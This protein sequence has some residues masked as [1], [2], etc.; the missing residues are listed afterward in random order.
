LLSI[1]SLLKFSQID[2]SHQVNRVSA[3]NPLSIIAGKVVIEECNLAPLSM[4]YCLMLSLMPTTRA[5][6]MQLLIGSSSGKILGKPITYCFSSD[7][8]MFLEVS[9]KSLDFS[10]SPPEINF[11]VL[12]GTSFAGIATMMPIAEHLYICRDNGAVERF[13]CVTRSSPKEEDTF[14][15]FDGAEKV[16]HLFFSSSVMALSASGRLVSVAKDSK[17]EAKQLSIF[18][19]KQCRTLKE[20][21]CADS[22]EG[23]LAVAGSGPLGSLTV[24]EVDKSVDKPIYKAKPILNTRLNIPVPEDNR[25]IAFLGPDRVVVGTALG[26]LNVFDISSAEKAIITRQVFEKGTAIRALYKTGNN[27]QVI[28]VDAQN[29]IELYDVARGRGLGRFPGHEGSIL[30]VA[31]ARWKQRNLLIT[32]SHDRYMRIFD[33]NT[34]KLLFK[35]YLKQVPRALHVLI[36]Q[37]SKQ[38]LTDSDEERLWDE[39]PVAISDKRRKIDN[40]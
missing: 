32:G 36:K 37:D 34:R 23:K 26:A 40:N 38:D 35:Q 6:K 17:D 33:F 16:A 9:C 11:S 24:F 5:L 4:Q 14:L 21:V 1:V 7:N 30:C 15:P 3:H 8:S 12:E 25:S 18:K 39:L 2:M 28:L 19:N 22:F 31:L 13:D 29:V 20:I 27:D 10:N